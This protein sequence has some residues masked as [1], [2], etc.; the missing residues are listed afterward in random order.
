MNLTIQ[1]LLPNAA[2]PSKVT[3]GAA[4][5]ELAYRYLKAQGLHLIARNVHYSCGEIDLIMQD[6]NCL[7]FVEVRYRRNIDFGT[8][9]ETINWH[10]QQRLRTTADQYLHHHPTPLACRF[11]V[12]AITGN[13][14]LEWL[15]NAF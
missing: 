13:H 5:E 3:I 14:A 1:Q 8:P 10:K 12:I 11:D 7:V 9:A 15:Q 6:A 4:K 2:Q